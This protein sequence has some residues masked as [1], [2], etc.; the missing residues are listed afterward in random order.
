[1]SN[2]S[3]GRALPWPD[4]A[5]QAIACA[6]FAALSFI[7]TAAAAPGSST[8]PIPA[9]D[10][11]SLTGQPIRRADLLGQPT[12]LIV[13][14]GRDAAA[15]TRAWA[16]S[17]RSALAA[18]ARMRDVLAVDLPFFMDE[19]DAIGRAKAKIP[20]RYHDQT[21]LTSKDTLTNALGVG[22]DAA[23]AQVFL[24]DAQGRVVVRLG[25][26]PTPERLG[27]LRSALQ[28]LR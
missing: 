16:K 6:L 5:G 26:D 17:L 23:Q 28:G 2:A 12:V 25:G 24:L 7:G 20:K 10:A 15:S 27:E 21:W 13:T 3:S 22:P 1:M 4:R 14:P 8:S 19:R 18:D 11:I 9:F